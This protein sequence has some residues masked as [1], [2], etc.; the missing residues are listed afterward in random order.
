LNEKEKI[1]FVCWCSQQGGLKAKTIKIYLKALEN[2]GNLLSP[3][4]QGAASL[5]NFL[6]QGTEKGETGTGRRKTT[7]PVTLAMLEAIK[8]ELHKRKWKTWSKRVIW[9]VCTVA[10]WGVFRLGELLP[11]KKREF[12]KFSDLLW[13]DIEFAGKGVWITIKSPKVVGRGAERVFLEKLKEK[14]VCPVRALKNLAK[15]GEAQDKPVFLINPETCLTRKVFLNSVNRLLTKTTFGAEKIQGKSFRSGI[16]SEVELLPGGFREKHIKVLGR[17]AGI[18]CRAYMR[19]DAKE[20]QKVFRKVSKNL[21]K[22]FLRRKRRTLEKETAHQ[23][24]TGQQQL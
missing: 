19:F 7:V 11:T 10:Y 15:K 24:A 8:A 23:S 22:S 21:L 2:L 6:L 1:A 12:D 9:G 18:S 4:S 5:K 14:W 20:K 3:K 16:P 17:W 13:S